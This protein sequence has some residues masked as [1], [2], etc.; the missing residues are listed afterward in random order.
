MLQEGLKYK[1]LEENTVYII[2]R[3]LQINNHKVGNGLNEAVI[4]DN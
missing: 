4:R 2:Q 3:E 1:Q